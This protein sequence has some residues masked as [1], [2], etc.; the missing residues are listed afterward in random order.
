MKIPYCIKRIYWFFQRAYF[1]FSDYDTWN[2]D[3]YL[4]TII[5]GGLKHLKQYSHSA[6]PSQEEF[7]IMIEGF[8]ANLLMIDDPSLYDELKPIFDR[9]ME[10]FHKYFNYLW[11]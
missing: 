5:I 4:A 11:D 3:Y 9:G 8:E 2:F 6:K 7:D 10:L 1:G